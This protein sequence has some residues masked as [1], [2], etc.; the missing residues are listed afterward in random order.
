MESGEVILEANRKTA[1]DP[2]NETHDRKE[3]FK[4]SRA[5]SQSAVTD[6]INGQQ[7]SSTQQSNPFNDRLQPEWQPIGALRPRTTTGAL[8]RAKI[9]YQR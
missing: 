9:S 2:A 5:A 4:V 1:D 8:L 7:S 3:N 6:F